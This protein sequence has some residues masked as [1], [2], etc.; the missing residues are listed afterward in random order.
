MSES[1]RSGELFAAKANST[2]GGYPLLHREEKKEDEPSAESP[3]VE[4]PTVARVGFFSTASAVVSSAYKA[5][6]NALG[7]STKPRQL[8]T[9]LDKEVASGR[10]DDVSSLTGGHA[11]SV[12][13][14]GGGGNGFT[15]VARKFS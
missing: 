14:G 15:D 13:R 9:E 10:G 2:H 5:V 7:S 6:K 12:A 3:T 11:G 4:T 1:M 8:E